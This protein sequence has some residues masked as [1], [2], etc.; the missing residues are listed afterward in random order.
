MK[1]IMKINSLTDKEFIE[2]C[3]LKILGRSPDKK[4]EMHYMSTLNLHLLTREDIMVRFITS[5]EFE[6]E[7]PSQ[8]CLTLSGKEPPLFIERVYDLNRL[9]SHIQ[10]TWEYLGE[11]EPYWSVASCEQFKSSKIEGTRSQFYNSGSDNVETLFKILERNGIDH[12]LLKTCLEYGCGLG[13]V[14]CWLA[15]RFE[16]VIGQDISR[17]HLQLAK[18]YL[19]E[20]GV[21][22]VA[23]QHI[24]KVQ[25]MGNFPMVDLVYSIIV[26][27]H[28][29]PPIIRVII[30]EF[31]RALNPGGVAVFQVPTYIMGYKFSLR[32][33]LAN[34]AKKDEIEMHVLPQ[35]EIFDIINKE[36]CNLI[37]VLEDNWTGL[38]RGV[39]S[40]TFVIQ[41][42]KA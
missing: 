13:R 2:F 31:L 5:E 8:L 4:G 34:E 38:M 26:L 6:L 33:Y 7:K 24:S 39:R 17:S 9:F 11:T 10:N 41:K 29:P 36:K 42:N 18:Q 21:H 1:E 27:Q 14:T 28:N 22:N 32:E 16:R 3:Y 19:D 20:I 23:Y 30:Q 40:N 35:K 37:E 15:K 12:T 25:E